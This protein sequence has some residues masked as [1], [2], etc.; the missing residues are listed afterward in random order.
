MELV[1]DAETVSLDASRHE[2]PFLAASED[3]R[4]VHDAMLFPCLLTSLQP[5][6][7]LTYRLWPLSAQ[8]TE[9]VADIFFHPAAFVPG[10]DP[11]DVYDFWERVN[12]EDRAICEG[13]QLGLRAG[14]FSPS[15]YA[16][17]ED[18]VHA[19]DRLV[20]RAYL[21]EGER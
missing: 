5:D 11:H 1:A 2:R 18:G 16:T 7:F 4:R 6:Y 14:G 8:R 12:A 21:R 17:V 19:F 10:F 9:V 13:Q 20:A 3:R 15:C